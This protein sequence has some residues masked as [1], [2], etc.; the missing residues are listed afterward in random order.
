MDERDQ[1]QIRELAFEIW[2]KEG[3]PEGRDL[4]H[5]LNAEAIWKST[6]A[7]QPAT[8]PKKPASRSRGKKTS[9]LETQE[10]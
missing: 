6:H 9:I 8:K 4:E 2:Q 1:Q 3:C 7:P 10:S 5:W